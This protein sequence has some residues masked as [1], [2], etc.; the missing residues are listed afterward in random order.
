MVN[1]LETLIDQLQRGSIS[2]RQFAQAI[3]LAVAGPA[4]VEAQ[5]GAP[6]PVPALSLNHVHLNVLDLEKSIAFYRDVFGAAILDRIRAI[7]CG[8][9]TAQS[10]PA[11]S[12][13]SPALPPP[14]SRTRH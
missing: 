13:A 8:R 7:G 14:S 11:R 9:P 6:A 2:R 10:T 1:A 3:L 5:Q 12:P 4:A